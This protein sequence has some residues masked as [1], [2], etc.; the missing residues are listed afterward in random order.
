MNAIFAGAD[1]SGA[2]TKDGLRVWGRFE[3]NVP[4]AAFG[5][6]FGRGSTVWLEEQ[7]G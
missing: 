3:G 5:V 7:G 1:A 2:M 4:D 6:T